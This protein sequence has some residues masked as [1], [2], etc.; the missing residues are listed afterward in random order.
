MI[1][2]FRTKTDLRTYNSSKKMNLYILVIIGTTLLLSNCSSSSD[3]MESINNDPTPVNIVKTPPFHGTIFLDPDIVTSSDPSTF[4]KTSYVGQEIRTMFDRRVND[5]VEEN[6]FLFETVFSDGFI[7][8]IQVNPEFQTKELAQIEAE[9]YGLEIG[10][11]PHILKTSVETVWI[12]KGVQP[13]G[14]GNKNILIHTGQSIE[15]EKD[16]ILEET[17]IHEASHT[18]L[19][20]THA[21][22]N[23]WLSSQTSDGN[24]ISTYARDNPVREDIA[25]TF[26]V[27]LAVAYRSDKISESLKNTIE[28]TVPNRIIYFK[29]QSFNVSPIE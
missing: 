16:G 3:N 8:E 13:F 7:I 28:T 6:A 19:D 20:E 11:L 26:L 2:F 9:K 27:Y 24:Y 23:G 15:Y 10:R 4:E 14:G 1:T 21:R 25:E 18:S 29:N 22:S 17:L 5:W 12:H